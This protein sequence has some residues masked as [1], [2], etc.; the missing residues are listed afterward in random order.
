MQPFKEGTIIDRSL[1][2]MTFCVPSLSFSNPLDK[3]NQSN[4][5]LGQGKESVLI[6]LDRGKWSLLGIS[7][8]SHLY[9][10][11]TPTTTWLE[12]VEGLQV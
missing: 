2:Y 6:K 8:F 9:S 1:V 5:F 3:S 10:S 7:E 4:I 12:N 11:M